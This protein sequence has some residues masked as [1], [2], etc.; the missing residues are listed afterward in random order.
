MAT[1]LATVRALEWVP[2]RRRRSGRL[3]GSRGGS[4]VAGPAGLE[5]DDAHRPDATTA[6]AATATL[7]NE[8]MGGNLHGTREARRCG[9]EGRAASTVP[10]TAAGA[11]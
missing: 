6:T 4:D 8:L 1:P 10:S 11:L 7:A 2:A 5:G 9:I 3:R